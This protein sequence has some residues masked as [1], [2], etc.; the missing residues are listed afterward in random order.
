VKLKTYISSGNELVFTYL[1]IYSREETEKMRI[2]KL[3]STGIVLSTFSLFG[4][5]AQA[6]TW[7]VTVTNLT[8]GNHFT[9]IVMTAHPHDVNLFKVGQTASTAMEHLAECGHTDPLLAT[10]DVGAA[11]DDTKV[12]AGV[13]APGES[14]SQTLTVDL[15]A[16]P[17]PSHLSVVSMVLPTNDAFLGLGGQHIEADAGTYTFFVNAYDAGTE[18]NDEV[19]MTTGSCTYTDTGMMP[20]APGS[21]AGSNGTGVSTADTNNKIHIHRGVL[22]DEDLTG[23]KSD[24]VNTIHRWQNPVARVVVTVTP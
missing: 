15:T 7:E 10:A 14:T 21:D 17:A 20:G 8:H 18:Q 16:S 19:L 6:A 4:F 1:S 2:N 9:P 11:D 5:N 12:T 22:G 13:L 24:L 3:I 23:G